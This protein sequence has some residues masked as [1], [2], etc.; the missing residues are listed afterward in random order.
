VL[1]ELTLTAERITLRL[2]E[3]EDLQITARGGVSF[4]SRQRERVFR[5]EGVQGLLIKNDQVTP[6]R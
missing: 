2:V 4:V 5:E 1:R 6:L 3:G